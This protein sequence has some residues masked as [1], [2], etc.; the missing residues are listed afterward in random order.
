MEEETVEVDQAAEHVLGESADT[1]AMQEK[2]AQVDEV[3]EDVVLQEVKI[4]LL[5]GEDK[6][7]RALA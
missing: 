5:R 4:V 1:V 3:R 7:K 6:K 2:L